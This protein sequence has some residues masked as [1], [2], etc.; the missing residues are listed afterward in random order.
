MRLG[1]Q[2]DGLLSLPRRVKQILVLAADVL[3]ALLAVWLAFYLRID[4]IGRPVWQQGY[5]YVAAVVLFVP[6]FVRMGLYRAVFRYAGL[7][8]L[9]TTATAV[10]IYGTLFFVVVLFARWRGVPRSIGLIQ[11][12]VFLLL[13]GGW[14]LLVRYLL[15]ETMV[16]QDA[17]QAKGRLLI[18]GAGAAGVQ[19][20]S[21]LSVMRQFSVRGF[22]D[23]DPG[24]IGREINGRPIIAPEEVA[25]FVRRHDVTEVLLAIPSLEAQ[26]RRQIIEGLQE[27]AVRVRSLPGML[28]LA[29]GR[30]SV[31]DFQELDLDDLL[32]R[33]PVEPDRV[34]LA[35][36]LRHRVV[37]VTGAGGSIGAE[38][39]RQIVREQ[40]R[41]VVLV[42]HNEYGLYAIDRELRALCEHE[43]RVVELVPQLGSIRNL[44]RLRAL[45]A[46]HAPDSVFHAAA[47]KHVPMVQGSPT[48][49][50][51]NNLFGTLNVVRAAL[52]VGVAHFVLISTDKAVRPTNV[53]G[54][55]KRVAE[56]VLQALA[57]E[58][59]VDFSVV[60][61]N[62]VP[63]LVVNRTN[64]SMVRFGNVLG[65]SGSVVP[66]F[67]RQLRDG[68]PLTV[69]DAEVTRYFMTI[70]EAA[71]LVLQAGALAQGG[72][73]FLLDMGQPV[74]ILDLARR[75]IRLS[76]STVRD[77]EHPD[78]EIEIRFVGLRPGEKL[79]EELLIGDHPEP[80]AHPRIMKARE[81]RLQ[82][83]E[84]A[85]V[86]R[87]LRT[88]AREGDEA[89]IHEVFAQVVS[90]YTARPMV[91]DAEL[92]TPRADF[93]ARLAP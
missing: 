73:V 64:L 61:E 21:A 34:L 33:A 66:L 56:L 90:G 36:N 43:G 6:V 19:T 65:S 23:N 71:Q 13:A 48:E 44:R 91:S 37:L 57:V 42:E 55:T 59:E 1:P 58:S 7:R 50:V 52:E 25:D 70:P 54:A 53:M 84:L 63:R 26:R 4:Q 87:R 77:A 69:T 82:W 46:E 20:A 39:C 24:K 85:L 8:A 29:T 49:G 2:L 67:R 47:Y 68:G 16:P 40:P 18:Y 83:A 74:K 12:I 5:V 62:E 38:L 11:P 35:K 17:E 3:A 22:V 28:D 45:F 41:R 86:L 93:D 89:A 72:E 9:V 32:G 60:D 27:A 51:M 75:M 76:G 80:T 14:R 81:A 15:L 79:Y 30:V 31:S 78:G 88:A 10:A 92:V